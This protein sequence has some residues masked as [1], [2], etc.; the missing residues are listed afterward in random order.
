[1]AIREGK[2]ERVPGLAAE[3]V[4]LK[5]EVIVTDG[6]GSTRSAKA[7]TSTIPIVMAQDADPVGTGIVASLARPGG[8]ITGLSNLRPELSGKRLEL[9]KEIVPTLS[10]VAVFRTS[11]S[12]GDAQTLQETELAAGVLGLKLQYLDVLSSN[13]FETAFRKASKERADAVVMMVAGPVYN[14]HRTHVVE[15]AAKNRLPAI[16]R[17]R[18]DVEAGGLMFY[19]V[20]VTDLVRRAATY[21]DKILKGAKPADLPVEQPTEVRVHR[22]SQSGE[23]D[24]SVDSTQRAGAGGQSDQI[25]EVR[26][27]KSEIG[28][29]GQT[30]MIKKIIFLVLCSLLLAPCS[31]VEAQQPTKVLRIGLLDASTAAGSAVLWDTLREELRKL[32]WIEGKNIVFEYRFA[33]QKL[34]RLPELAAELVRLKVDLI[35]VPGVLPALAAKKATPTIPIVLANAP[36]PVGAG[37]VASL[38]RPGGNITGL[39]SLGTELNTKRLEILKDAVP[40]LARVGVL[41]A[42]ARLEANTGLDLQ[43]KELRAAALALK[44]KLEEIETQLDPKGLESAFQTAKQKQVGAIMTTTGSP[45]FAERKRIVE[46]AGKFRLPAIYPDKEFVD[47][48]G[49]MS[50]GA[51]STDLYRRA[52]VYVDKILKGA[53]AGDLPVQQAT[54]FEFVINFKAAKQIGLTIPVR[55]LE[56]ANRVIR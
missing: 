4:R 53:K 56:R 51:D 47:E 10:R 16:Y 52:A 29:S 33:E 44:L 3:L 23:A 21:V 39:A 32:G 54:K 14:P 41:G 27:Q 18:E 50:Y 40:E 28:E 19:G 43:L 42:R 11:T 31:A 20:N 48:G 8:N 17:N 34:E 45:F 9:L 49:L 46:L 24:R 37:L 26:D 15:L 6:S 1:M 2:A 25:T 5:V 22:Q 36:D 35:L 30:A 12:P 13:D 55:V 7:A 38:A